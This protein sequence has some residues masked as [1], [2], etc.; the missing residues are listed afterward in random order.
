MRRWCHDNLLYIIAAALVLCVCV[1]AVLW[2][3]LI[4]KRSRKDRTTDASY[5]VVYD[6]TE[7]KEKNR[8]TESKIVEG[9]DQRFLS[10]VEKPLEALPESNRHFINQ[11]LDNQS[12]TP[13]FYNVGS[14]HQSLFQGIDG[15][16]IDSSNLVFYSTIG[17]MPVNDE[18]FDVDRNGSLRTCQSREQ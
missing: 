9:N 18:C 8:A 11:H 4:C 12:E 17:V 2:M 6:N 7:K 13:R 16:S 5:V 3:C 10:L 15:R 1:A 14:H